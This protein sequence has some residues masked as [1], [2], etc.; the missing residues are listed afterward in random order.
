MKVCSDFTLYIIC[1]DDKCY[2]TLNNLCLENLVLIEYSSFEDDTLRIAK[3]NRKTRE[4]LWT[5]SS[6]EIKYILEKYNVDHVTYIDADLYFYSDPSNII[7]TF[8]KSDNDVSLISHRYSNHYENKYF[9]K[10]CGKYCVEFDSFKN[11]ENGRCI[12]NWWC[13][14]CFEKCPDKPSK[15]AFGDQKYLDYFEKNFK[16]VNI[17]ED[18]GLGIAPWNIDDFKY[19]TNRKIENIQNRN[20][21]D[22]VF[23]HFHSLA[24]FENYANINVFVRPG[25]KDEKLV[26]VLYKSYLNEI[27][28]TLFIL[29][30]SIQK[31]ETKNN[32]ILSR[33]ISYIFE[34]KDLIIAVRKLY[35]LIFFR[36]KDIIYY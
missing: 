20:T 36:K 4:F 12:L 33:T 14:K 7:E 35:R 8:L 10:K 19:V 22:L 11:N 3:S 5:C 28:N 18:F 27:K 25:K 13:Q 16:G 9:E 15:E 29:N 24:L 6:F 23:Y 17:Y 26:N 1:F 2:H 21:G 32:N 34:E 31:A 30:K